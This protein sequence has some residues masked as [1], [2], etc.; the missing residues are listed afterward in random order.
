MKRYHPALETALAAIEDR[1]GGTVYRQGKVTW[2]ETSRIAQWNPLE[3]RIEACPG[4][5]AAERA[6]ITRIWP[7]EAPA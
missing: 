6:I 4:A 1:L 2:H 5:T 3:S 7:T